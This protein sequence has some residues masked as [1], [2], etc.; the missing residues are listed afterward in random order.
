ATPK[1]R[2]PKKLPA[3]S[4]SN[5][6]TEKSRSRNQKVNNQH[7]LP[8]EIFQEEMPLPIL[9]P[10]QTNSSMTFSPALRANSSGNQQVNSDFAR[11]ASQILEE[12]N[13]SMEEVESSLSVELS[14]QVNSS[15]L[16]QTK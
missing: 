6:K 16:D 15:W 14:M 9:S 2:S 12:P 3:K 1:K 13:L 4:T 8:N 10:N 5:I 11:L 7:N